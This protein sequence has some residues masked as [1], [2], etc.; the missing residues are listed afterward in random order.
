MCICLSLP[1]VNSPHHIHLRLTARFPQLFTAFSLFCSRW[2]VMWWGRAAMGSGAR[3]GQ[4]LVVPCLVATPLQQAFFNSERAALQRG[5]RESEVRLRRRARAPRGLGRATIGPQVS[6]LSRLVARSVS[7]ALVS[8][9][10]VTIACYIAS[11]REVTSSL[12]YLQWK[13]WR[14]FSSEATFSLDY[15]MSAMFLMSG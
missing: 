13:L 9:C 1:Q 8:A 14:A 2:C 10:A 3:A 12:R 7:V 11:R 4:Y 6:S 15:N 5:V